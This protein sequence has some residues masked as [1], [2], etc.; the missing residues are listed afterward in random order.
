MSVAKAMYARH[1][2]T[3]A[4]TEF[5]MVIREAWPV[6]TVVNIRPRVG[7]G[8]IPYTVVDHRIGGPPFLIQVKNPRSGSNQWFDVSYFFEAEVNKDATP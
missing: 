2:Y 1:C 7:A 3:R 4:A 5:A 6:G 8:H